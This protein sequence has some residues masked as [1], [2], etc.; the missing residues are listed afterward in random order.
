ML[1]EDTIRTVLVRQDSWGNTPADWFSWSWIQSRISVSV[2]S[3]QSS[4]NPGQYAMQ[5]RYPQ[6]KCYSAKHK[7]TYQLCQCHLTVSYH[8]IQYGISREEDLHPIPISSHH[9]L[10][11]HPVYCFKRGGL[12]NYIN[13]TSLS[14][15]VIFNIPFQEQMTYLLNWTYSI[16]IYQYP[17]LSREHLHP[18]L[19]LDVELTCTALAWQRVEFESRSWTRTRAMS[20]GLELELEPWVQALN[21]NSTHN[22]NSILNSW[23]WL[24]YHLPN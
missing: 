4:W 24:E 14:A 17:I 23:V 1:N 8:H 13:I 10:P 12:T 19:S 16:V 21:L 2:A 20:S 9:Q 6:D 5:R 7:L 3:D 15:T 22:S 11:S 18:E